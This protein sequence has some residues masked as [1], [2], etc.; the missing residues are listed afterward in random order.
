V[1]VRSGGRITITDTFA[2]ATGSIG[3]YVWDV[4]SYRVGANR[5][6]WLRRFP[7]TADVIKTTTPNSCSGGCGTTGP[8]FATG[9]G[10]VRVGR[11]RRNN[12]NQFVNLGR[13]NPFSLRVNVNWTV[14]D[15]CGVIEAA[16]EFSGT[17]DGGVVGTVFSTPQYR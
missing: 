3:S 11:T 6:F 13:T 10:S 17:R 1:V 8:S 7:G 4:R 5:F 16:Y 2:T 9:L 12:A 15:G 14:P